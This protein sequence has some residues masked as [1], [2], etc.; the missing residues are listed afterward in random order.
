M[1]DILWTVM[2][3]LEGNESRQNEIALG[4]RFGIK[5]VKYL[6]LRNGQFS[7]DLCNYLREERHSASFDIDKFIANIE[8][9]TRKDMPDEIVAWLK[10]FTYQKEMPDFVN[11]V[12]LIYE[13]LF[14]SISWIRRWYLDDQHDEK[15]KVYC[16]PILALIDRVVGK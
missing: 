13:R 12:L 5:L 10:T 11:A 16:A 14:E 8:T 4:F 6:S 7:D 1:D 3:T 2:Q 9:V 15:L